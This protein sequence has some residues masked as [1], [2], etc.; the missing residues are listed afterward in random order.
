MKVA[1]NVAKKFAYLTAKIVLV[2]GLVFG[3]IVGFSLYKNLIAEKKA[4]EFCD[5]IVLGSDIS[6]AFTKAE[7]IKIRHRFYPEESQHSFAFPGF[8][9]GMALCNVSVDNGE[10]VHKESQAFW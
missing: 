1:S 4:Q 2:I 10:I 5:E 9:I 8:G 6:L 7:Q 3:G